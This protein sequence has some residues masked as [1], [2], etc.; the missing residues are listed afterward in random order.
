M[1]ILVCIKQVPASS[2]VEVDP[3]T[4]VLKRDGSDSKMN[5]YD[6]FALETALC[7]REQCG[8]EVTVLTMGPPQAASVIKEAYSMGADKGILLS[9]RAFAGADVL[10][11]CLWA[12]K[13]KV[14]LI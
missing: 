5:P 4:G 9:D 14:I 13:P 7:L 2:Q 3:V 10:V 11:L 8:G 1:K 6:L 12:L